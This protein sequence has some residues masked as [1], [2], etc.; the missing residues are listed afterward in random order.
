MKNIIELVNWAVPVKYRHYPVSPAVKKLIYEEIDEM[1]RLGAID[2]RD[3]AWRN[4]ITLVRKPGKNSLCLDA[5][6]LKELK[7][8]SFVSTC[9]LTP[10]KGT[11][12]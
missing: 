11:R 5:R 9:R 10:K 12:L 7:L 4:T 1:L 8:I 6:K 2:K 3:S